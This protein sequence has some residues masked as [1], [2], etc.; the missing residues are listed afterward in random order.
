MAD[1]AEKKARGI[2]DAVYQKQCE[3]GVNSTWIYDAGWMPIAEAL[4]DV[5]A[6]AMEEACRAVCVW[7]RRGED[8][9]K[10]P[11]KGTAYHLVTGTEAACAAAEIRKAFDQKEEARRD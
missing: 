11:K 7:C 2:C 10:T 6:E 1:W 4:R 8:L 9:R 5:R 3:Q